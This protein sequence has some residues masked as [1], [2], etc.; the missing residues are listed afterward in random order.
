VW[1]YTGLPL[2]LKRE[3]VEVFW[4]PC[5]FIPSI[6]VCKYIVTIHDLS[7]YIVAQSYPWLRRKYYQYLIR[8]AVKRADLI[9]AISQTTKNDLMKFFSLPEDKI[10]VIYNG[11]NSNF[12]VDNI[13]TNFSVLQEKYRLPKE[14]IFT[15]GVLEP[16]K[17]VERVIR[18][19][20]QL[21]QDTGALPALVIGG[22]KKYGWK[23][24]SL[25][26]LVDLLKLNYDTVF[27]G[28][29]EHDD[30][31]AI[32][33]NAQL[34]ILPSLYEGFGLPVIE[35]MACGTPVITSNTSSLPEVSGNA[36]VLVDPYNISEIIGAM[37]LVLTNEMKRREMIEKGLENVKRFSWQKAAQAIIELFESVYQ[38]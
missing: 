12:S 19:Y 16:K 13:Q 9:V 21:K 20:H 33:H 3:N 1:E 28:S 35:A 25:F 6:K 38:N 30:L 5:N 17:N 22:S 29:I 26:R 36:A 14:Y 32:Y 8:N 24:E 37:K 15:L 11:F 2:S 18:A 4:G 10:K 23:N 34:F 31:P 27:T 7:A